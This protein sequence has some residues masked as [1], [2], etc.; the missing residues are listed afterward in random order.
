MVAVGMDP[1]PDHWAFA[2]LPTK[3]PT[4]VYSADASIEDKDANK[5]ALGWGLGTGC[6]HQHFLDVTDRICSRR[7]LP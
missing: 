5:V 6:P 7:M 4:G 3:L 1:S 2:A